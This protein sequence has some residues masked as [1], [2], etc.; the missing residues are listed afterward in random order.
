MSKGIVKDLTVRIQTLRAM[1]NGAYA[2][3]LQYER[4]MLLTN[5]SRPPIPA[6]LKNQRQRRKLE[7][8]TGRRKKR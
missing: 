8:Q 2:A 1:G 5:G 3:Q 7:R 6:N 4:D